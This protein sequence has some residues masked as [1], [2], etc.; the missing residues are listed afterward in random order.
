MSSRDALGRSTSTRRQPTHPSHISQLESAQFGLG[1]LR[2]A[3]STGSTGSDESARGAGHLSIVENKPTRSTSLRIINRQAGLKDKSRRRTVLNPDT[4]AIQAHSR[5]STELFT[6]THSQ[7]RS[8]T[9]WTRRRIAKDDPAHQHR[10]A[11]DQDREDDGSADLNQPLTEAQRIQS[12][13]RGRKLAQLFGAEP[14][15]ALYRVTSPFEDDSPASP[16]AITEESI[17]YLALPSSDLPSLPSIYPD[18]RSSMHL[19]HTTISPISTSFASSDSTADP[20][21]EPESEQRP[22]T[23]AVQSQTSN[24]NPDSVVQPQDPHE[25]SDDSATVT[26]RRRRLQA[27]KLARFFGIA[28]ND[29]TNPAAGSRN[30]PERRGTPS[31]DVGVKIQER[32]WFWGRTEGGYSSRARGQDADMNDVIALLRQMPRA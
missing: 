19:S 15:I 7:R 3:G 8:V 14:P 10:S 26:F 12:I 27:A 23:P 2:R 31:A 4:D 28:Y 11:A 20:F 17:E 21:Q 29:L 18:D 32:G 16:S 30:Q 1:R 5:R 25:R 13:R 22:A 6:P 9:L 24:D